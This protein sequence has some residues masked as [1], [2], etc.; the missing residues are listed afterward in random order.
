MLAKVA[1]LAHTRI[2][3]LP[4]EPNGEDNGAAERV[5][6]LRRFRLHDA[7]AAH[8]HQIAT[9]PARS[10]SGPAAA[11]PRSRPSAPPSRPPSYYPAESAGTGVI[12]GGVG[13]S[14]SPPRGSRY[15]SSGHA[16]LIFFNSRRQSVRKACTVA[17]SQTFDGSAP[18]CR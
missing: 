10:I 2:C 8:V 18:N 6:P 11:P 4:Q 14:T 9:R 3:Q 13:Y 16:I 12:R 5:T 15:V 7:T 1:D 17:A